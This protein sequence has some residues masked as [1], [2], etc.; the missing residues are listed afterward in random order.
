MDSRIQAAVG[1]AERCAGS[2]ATSLHRI[3]SECSR[4]RN[5]NLT[6]PNSASPSEPP[7]LNLNH[8]NP[9]RKT[10]SHIEESDAATAG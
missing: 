7:K 6:N 5:R 2:I 4:N 10:G 1:R 9:S 8:Q 3:H